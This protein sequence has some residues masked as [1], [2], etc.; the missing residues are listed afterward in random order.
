MSVTLTEKAPATALSSVTVKS[1]PVPSAA[2]MFST[3]TWALS[4]S[5]R[6]PAAVSVSVTSALVED[7]LTVKVSVPSN[8]ESSNVATVNCWVSAAV[9]A[10]LSVATTLS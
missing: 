10:K 6:M 8:T 5:V 4:L 3:V 9:P 7:R 2:L 1:N